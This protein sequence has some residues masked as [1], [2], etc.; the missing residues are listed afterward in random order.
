MKINQTCG[1]EAT[2]KYFIF[3]LSVSSFLIVIW[4]TADSV[5]FSVCSH[6]SPLCTKV[7]Y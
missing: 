1:E 7:P 4:V 6:N 3:I 5:I 2:F